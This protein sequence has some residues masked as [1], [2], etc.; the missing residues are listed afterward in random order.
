MACGFAVFRALALVAQ[1]GGFHRGGGGKRVA[2]VGT[3]CVV[4]DLPTSGC[5]PALP[6]PDDWPSSFDIWDCL[7]STMLGPPMAGGGLFHG[8]HDGNLWPSA[9]SALCP[10]SSGEA[11]ITWPG[12]RAFRPANSDGRRRCA[13]TN[14]R[15]SLPA[16]SRP[17]NGAGGT[18]KPENTY[19]RYSPTCCSIRFPF[20]A[21]RDSLGKPPEIFNQPIYPFVLS[22][23]PVRR[24]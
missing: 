15:D 23:K 9:A 13:P 7:V 18:K 6:G 11:A 24:P 16:G 19:S 20:S 8:P 2:R 4:Q 3:R 22:Q 12:S 10:L 5:W 17:T 14:S 21:R 1:R